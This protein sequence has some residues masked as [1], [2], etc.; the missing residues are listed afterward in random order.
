MPVLPAARAARRRGGAGAALDVGLEDL[1]RLVGD[2]VL[3]APLGLGAQL[4]REL[5]ALEHRAVRGAHRGDGDRLVPDAAGRDRRVGVGH[6]ERGDAAL[7]AAERLGRVAVELGGDAHL[8]GRLLDVLRAEVERELHVHGVVGLQRRLAQVDRAGVRAVVGLGLDV[9]VGRVLEVER[10]GDV[11]GR[12]GVHAAVQRGHQRHRLERRARLA[13]ALG[14]E[15]E[16]RLA[17]VRRRRHREDLAVARVDGHDRRRGPD[18][19]DAPGDRGARRVLLVRVDRR[20]HAQAA[21]AHLPHRER[22]VELVLDVVEEVVLAPRLEVLG[23]VEVQR[24]GLA[25]LGLRLGDEALLGHGVEHVVAARLRRGRRADGR[26]Q[27]RRLRE[28]GQQRGLAQRQ[29]PRRLV[30]VGLGRRPHAQRGLAAVGAVRDGV[31][32]LREDPVL[33]VLVLEL[34]GELGLADL[35]LVAL[36][37]RAVERA[38]E[39][40]RQRRAALHLLARLEVL[41]RGADRRPRSRRPCA[42]RSAS[43]RSR[44]SRPGGS[45]GSGRSGSPCAGR[46]PG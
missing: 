5:L 36:L 11:G 2:A 31:Q 32:V 25:L 29:L 19:G 4:L 40:H 30:E 15:V 12:V 35:A 8:L 14:G 16:L 17:V 44:P 33:R 3:E 23:H 41:D 6:L 45:A 21:A 18:P 1:R 13:V 26:V 34:L 10:L 24:L 39:L 37:R 28:S 7:Q 43:P 38:D 42:C 9:P 27:R 22:L 46:A 20:V